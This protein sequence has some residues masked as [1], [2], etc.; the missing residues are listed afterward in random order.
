M[1]H[2]KWSTDPNRILECGLRVSRLLGALALGAIA[3][4]LQGV[5]Q[6]RALGSVPQFVQ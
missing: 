6:P 1:C 5:K 3:P 4:Q 2:W